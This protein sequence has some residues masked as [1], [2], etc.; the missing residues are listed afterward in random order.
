ML[1]HQAK[2]KWAAS[3]IVMNPNPVLVANEV[4]VGREK[5]MNEL[6]E[7]LWELGE[8]CEKADVSEYL[9]RA[10]EMQSLFWQGGE[11]LE[12]DW[13]D[14]SGDESYWSDDWSYCW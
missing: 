10:V 3:A 6:E 7:T 5:I 13:W 4:M 14:D 11:S 2:L 8:Q 9:T 12:E 1:A